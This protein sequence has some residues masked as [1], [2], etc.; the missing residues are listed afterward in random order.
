MYDRLLLTTENSRYT[1]QFT[2]NPCIVLA[3][4]EGVLGYE[5]ASVD[6]G[7]WTFRRDA[8]FK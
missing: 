2:V 6:G 1:K 3:L 5:R 4:V 8:E 7:Q